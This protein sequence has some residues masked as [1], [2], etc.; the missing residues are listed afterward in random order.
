MPTVKLTKRTVDAQE[1]QATRFTVW[2]TEISGFG[3]RVTPNGERTYVLKYRLAGQQRW[4]TIGR[5]GSPWTPEMARSEARRLLGE[6]AKGL[7]PAEKK[8]VDRNAL[9][10]A[11]LCDLY[12]REG[13][14]HK[15]PST[16]KVDRGRIRHHLNPLLG[17]KRVDAI[18]RAD[19]ERLLM[20]VARGKTAVPGVKEG[21]RKPGSVA[22][23]GNGV[24]ARC[25]SLLGTILEFAVKRR[26][27][28]TTQP[29]GLRRRDQKRWSGFSRIPRS[30][31]SRKALDQEARSVGNP[32]PTTAVRLLLLTGCRRSEI[33]VC[34]GSTSILSIGAS[35]FPTAR[36]AQRLYT[37]RTCAGVADLN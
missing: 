5:H 2:D 35:D 17:H 16:L 13:V 36:R 14:A 4:F 30:P 34:G 31:A 33:W 32:Y 7:D 22:A 15:K 23:G 12:L 24:A 10:L 1:P 26:C 25:V 9:T 18:T 6:V 27:G 19:V 29:E 37:Q 3:L 11:G 28:P 20:D 8:S 21:Q